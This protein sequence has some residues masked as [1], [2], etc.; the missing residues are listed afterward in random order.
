MEAF[1]D[2]SGLFGI[3]GHPKAAQIAVAG[4][5]DLEHRGGL[6]AGLVVSDGG[7]L[8][9]ARG[10]G[11]VGEVFDAA[12]LQALPGRLAIG[13]VGGAAVAPGDL[14]GLAT[15]EGVEEQPLLVR[16][17]GGRIAVAMAGSFLRASAV[18]SELE[19]EGRFFSSVCDAEVLLHLLAR[20]SRSTFVNRLVD[21]LHDLHDG[22]WSLLLATEDRLVAVR[23]PYGL[24]P[25]MRGTLDGATV[26]GS[27]DCALRRVG[28]ERIAEVA[29]G[30]M[31]IVG[32]KPGQEPIS[33]F[34]FPKRDR[35]SCIR[36]VTGIARPDGTPFGRSAY[37]F[38]LVV[39]KRLARRA[40]CRDA[41]VV[42]G[43]PVSGSAIALGFA[44]E[45]G[46]PF[47]EALIPTGNIAPH[48]VT[49]EAAEPWRVVPGAVLARSVVLV[50]S[51]L[52]TGLPERRAVRLLR[53]EGARQVHLRVGGLPSG[54]SCRYGVRSPTDEELAINRFASEESLLRWLDVDS[55]G[56]L[57]S[58]DLEAALGSEDASSWCTRC[59]TGV[60]PIPAEAGEQLGL[61]RP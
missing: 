1:R 37:G 57:E 60:E 44:R 40:A 34:P 26:F 4:L 25:L 45:A 24:R 13:R 23:D 18:R 46:L 8:R 2:D 33:V 11:G 43:L 6:G 53:R 31:L 17:R 54:W 36:E 35:R 10:R 49:T 59:L 16:Y 3:A 32:V 61:F 58:Q 19:T 12:L 38:R 56:S 27:D 29:P 47:H 48:L 28:A 30:E 7:L 15:A 55:F 21:G 51:G 9:S 5:H 52:D 41:E 42:V 14:D 50:T 39:G 22:G 20:S